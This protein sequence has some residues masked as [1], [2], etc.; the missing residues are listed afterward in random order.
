[1]GQVPSCQGWRAPEPLTWPAFLAPISRLPSP[2]CTP[3]RWTWES[4]RGGGDPR[5]SCGK[6]HLGWH[7]DH[8]WSPDALSP[9][10]LSLPPAFQ[11]PA[12]MTLVFPL[13]RRP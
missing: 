10:G 1:M 5:K 11:V 12:L 13:S 2:S 8:R 4:C 7:P 9:T 3:L 6:P